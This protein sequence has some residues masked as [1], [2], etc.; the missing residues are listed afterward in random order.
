[1]INGNDYVDAS[2]NSTV[3]SVLKKEREKQNISLEELSKKIDYKVKR[4]TLFYYETGRSKIKVSTFIDICKA[5][6][7]NPE[8]VFDEINMKYF[9]NSKFNNK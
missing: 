7:L 1:V 4:Q 8:D 6:H 9:K 5:L 3:G 2:F